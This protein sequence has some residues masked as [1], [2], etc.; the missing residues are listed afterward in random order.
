MSAEKHSRSVA[1]VLVNRMPY[2]LVLTKANLMSGTWN[3]C[4]AVEIEAS[5]VCVIETSVEK[6]SARDVA[7]TVIYRIQQYS[8]TN[9][10]HQGSEPSSKDSTVA[11]RWHNTLL[12]KNEFAVQSPEGV[13]IL[14]EGGGGD[15]AKVVFTIIEAGKQTRTFRVTHD[16]ASYAPGLVSP[17]PLLFQNEENSNDN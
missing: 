17:G 10:P 15:H 5:E 12:A 13:E 16:E 11:I 9:S 2:K 4:P 1:V 8:G 14:R 3:K 6:K 7:A